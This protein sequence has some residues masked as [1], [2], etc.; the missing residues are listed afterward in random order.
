MTTS[1]NE[2][3]KENMMKTR[4]IPLYLYV[5]GA[6]TVL[7][8]FISVLFLTQDVPAESTAPQTSMEQAYILKDYQGKI[9]LYNRDAK[10]PQKV[11]DVYLMNLPELDQQ[12]LKKGIPVLDQAHLEKLLE[13]F[14]S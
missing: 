3:K 6:I 9:A 7:S 11:Y 1:H 13:D 4:K 5:T 14:D 2:R 10:T 12:N 8:L